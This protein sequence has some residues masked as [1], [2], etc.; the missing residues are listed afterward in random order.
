M[1]VRPGVKGLCK[2]SAKR[3]FYYGNPNV[4]VMEMSEFAAIILI[5]VGT[6]LLVVGISVRTGCV[7][8]G[9]VTSLTGVSQLAQ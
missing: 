9:T 3:Y 8:V 7:S 2:L 5:L 6:M 1:A 4:I